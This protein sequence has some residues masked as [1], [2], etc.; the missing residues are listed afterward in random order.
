MTL[1]YLPTEN[2]FSKEADTFIHIRRR[3]ENA[4]WNVTLFPKAALALF[5]NAAVD[6][7]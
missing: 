3:T 5:I 7:P 1:K 2:T 4:F 6:L